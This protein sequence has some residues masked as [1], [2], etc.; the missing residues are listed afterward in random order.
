MND[1]L[2]L[3]IY[4][5]VCV[6]IILLVAGIRIHLAEIPFER[7]EGEYAYAGQM[8]LKGS[9]PYHEVYN[10]KFP[11]VYFMYALGFKMFGESVAATRYL[12]LLLQ[13]IGAGFIFLLGRRLIN[14]L[15]GWLTAATFMLFNL[16]LA[17]QGIQSNAE[18]FV[19]A[20]L[21]PSLYFLYR[22]LEEESAIDLATSGALLATAC[23]MKQHA[24]LFGL[25]TVPWVVYVQRTRAFKYLLAY[26]AGGV[27]PVV[28]MFAYLWHVGVW[29]RFY[30]LTIQYAH[31][32][33]NIVPFKP[34][35]QQFYPAQH[36]G[37]NISA[38]LVWFGFASALGLVLPSKN[39]RARLFLLLLLVAS[40]VSVMPGFF[41]RR[42]YFLMMLP[43]LSLLFTY[44]AFTIA[45]YFSDRHRY[46]VL[47]VY[48]VASAAFFLGYE[49][50]LLFNT[51][52]E[53]VTEAMYP[54]TPFGAA[55]QIAGYIKNHSAPTDR[56]CMI[57]AEPQIFFLSQRKS[58]SGYI[59][60]YPLL[61]NQKYAPVMTD[62]FIAQS[63]QAKP[64]I[65]L[66]SSKALFEDGYNRDS[67]LYTWF[68]NFKNQY[69]LKAICAPVSATDL[70][71]LKLDTIAPVDT[72]PETV[73]Q[74][75]VYER[76][77]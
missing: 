20:F 74:I 53:Q 70:K 6:A 43:G 9:P 40:V 3:R 47:S 61:E 13:L 5:V 68:A 77:K 36:D 16:T 67:K 1:K 37:N 52:V 38:L 26:A 28:L 62:E 31:E 4:K 19:V 71:L 55:G 41:F 23:L 73:P 45:G 17:L 46:A 24:F 75:R 60:I 69:R 65:L 58:A 39:G 49:H 29:D 15:A 8:I 11:G 12:T 7:D 66:Y 59:Y 72:L 25:A 56:I 50:T 35:M 54:G 51:P 33:V 21:L 57:G 18:H 42:H 63:E 2:S 14:P 10:M 64:A 30:F 76:M 48:V 27:K 44:T 22:G 34:A 32:Y